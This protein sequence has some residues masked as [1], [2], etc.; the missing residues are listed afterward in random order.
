[1]PV[2]NHHGPVKVTKN[3]RIIIDGRQVGITALTIDTT[4]DTTDDDTETE[5]EEK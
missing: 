4:T 5:T 3:G 2:Y 1:M